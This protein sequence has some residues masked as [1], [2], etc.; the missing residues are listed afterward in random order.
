MIRKSELSDLM[1]ELPVFG[2]RRFARGWHIFR[3]CA[4]TT[5]MS[6]HFERLQHENRASTGH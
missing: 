1:S 4:T 3:V 6:Q 2:V 5:L